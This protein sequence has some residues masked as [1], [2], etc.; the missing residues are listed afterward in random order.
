M[1]KHLAICL[2]PLA[3][4][5]GLSVTALKVVC[6]YDHQPLERGQLGACSS[7][8]LLEP[9]HR[10]RPGLVLPINSSCGLDLGL[11]CSVHPLSP[12]S[13]IPHV[14][15]ILGLPPRT[16]VLTEDHRSHEE[17]RYHPQE[18]EESLRGVSREGGQ[19]SVR[20]CHRHLSTKRVI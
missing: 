17:A 8:H 11:G 13:S 7:H 14:L 15:G 12:C 4:D 19:V 3:V 18:P 20:F 6:T 16:L 2:D 9:G 5:G 10:H 1:S